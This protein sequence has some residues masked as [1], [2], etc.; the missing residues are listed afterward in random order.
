MDDNFEMGLFDSDNSF[1]LNFESQIPDLEEENQ[2][3]DEKN[4]NDQGES[5][6][7]DG[8]ENVAEGE[9]DQEE[10]DDANEDSESS[11]N[12]FSSVAT[13]LH[14]Q[15][16]LPSLDIEST[17]IESADDLASSIQNEVN[18]L[19]EKKLIS[20]FGEEGYEFISKG[21]KP[22]EVIDYQE[23]S[24]ILDSITED[25]LIEDI[26]LSKNVVYEDYLLRGMSPEQATKIIE[27]TLLAGDEVLIEDAKESLGNLKISNKQLLEKKALE[28]EK[29]AIEAEKLKADNELKIK[30]SIYNTESLG[31]GIELNKSTQDKVYKLMTT[32]VGNDS[33]G[34][35]ENA[36]MKARRENTIDFDTKL[37]YIYELTK[38]FTDFSK[39]GKSAKK[40]AISDLERAMQSNKNDYS[41]TPGYIQ[42]NESYSGGIQGDHLNL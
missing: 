3:Q 11:P 15:G 29:A 10:G 8:S 12:L 1:E 6:D 13:V 22:E 18:S 26:E 41:S 31:K 28:A 27:R 9:D 5:L 21:V 32:V 24:K 16:I 23:K 7:Q 35:P 39:F 37:Y 34:N 40:S 30:N 33:K 25:S 14:E 38:G 19:Y 4:I 17:K 36:L 20:T 2:D 42:D